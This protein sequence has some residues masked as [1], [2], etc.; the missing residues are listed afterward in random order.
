MTSNEQNTG[1]KAMIR[2]GDKVRIKPE[3]QDPGDDSVE[4]VALEDEDGGRVRIQ[5]QLGLEIN[6]NQVVEVSMLETE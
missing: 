4:W 3:F 5:P 6:P 2:R 1:A